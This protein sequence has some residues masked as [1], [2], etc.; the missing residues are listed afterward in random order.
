[1]A[2]RNYEV[3]FQISDLGNS[4]NCEF[5]V[6][7]AES[8]PDNVAIHINDRKGLRLAELTSQAPNKSVSCINLAD[9]NLLLVTKPTGFF[10]VTDVIM[11][12]TLTG[13]NG[14][15]MNLKVR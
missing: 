8:V 3:D 6:E 4:S 7:M 9:G 15:K 5:T 13:L 2:K 12:E 14:S 1:M 11:S 10:D